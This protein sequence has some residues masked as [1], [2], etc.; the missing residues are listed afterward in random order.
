MSGR[1]EQSFKIEDLWKIV[2]EALVDHANGVVID[3]DEVEDASTL[4]VA[5]MLMGHGVRAEVVAGLFDNR[6]YTIR[7]S[8]DGGSEEIGITVDWGTGSDPDKCWRCDEAASTT[9]VG[10]CQSCLLELR[11]PA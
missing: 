5:A 4:L 7:L 6:D 1:I 8:W 11:T 10:L 3:E 9:D 2:T